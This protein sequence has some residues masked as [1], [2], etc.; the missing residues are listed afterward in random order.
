VSVTGASVTGASVSGI[1]QVPGAGAA[2]VS[3]GAGKYTGEY[4]LTLAPAGFNV[5]STTLNVTG[6]TIRNIA[7]LGAFLAASAGTPITMENLMV[8]ARTEYAKLDKP[9]TAAEAKG[10]E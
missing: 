6:G 4:R 9:M 8:A 3:G 2:G 7:L 10:W 5:N 1:G